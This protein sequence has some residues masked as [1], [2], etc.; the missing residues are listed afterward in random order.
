M[1]AY[2]P[3]NLIGQK[4][5]IR[6]QPERGKPI[7]I[8]RQSNKPNLHSKTLQELKWILDDMWLAKQSM[9][10]AHVS[11]VVIDNYG[12]V[13]RSNVGA[14]LKELEKLIRERSARTTTDGF[15]VNMG[16]AEYVPYTDTEVEPPQI[17]KVVNEIKEREGEN[18]NTT[19]LDAEFYRRQAAMHLAT[20]E[21]L[22]GMPMADPFETG[23]I[24]CF[25]KYFGAY[26]DAGYQY[27]AIK[28]D[29]GWFITGNQKA[30]TLFSW[31]T[32]LDFIGIEAFDTIGVM[33]TTPELDIRKWWAGKQK[34]KE[35]QTAQS[36]A[37]EEKAKKYAEGTVVE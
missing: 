25:T 16:A 22:E 20:A 4:A 23:Q 37:D 27:A 3:A 12:T 30:N 33:V 5:T 9:A 35:I 7:A 29:N 14:R 31:A 28:A 24:I 10:D 13:N 18:V 26:G 32:L 2:D 21:K 36:V 19:P 11:Y 8:E 34:A 17:D 1:A 6:V 15:V